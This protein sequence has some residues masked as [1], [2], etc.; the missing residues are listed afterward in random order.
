LKVR[1]IL[2][3]HTNRQ[4]DIARLSKSRSK[5]DVDVQEGKRVPTALH[6]QEKWC[7]GPDAMNETMVP[8]PPTK[9]RD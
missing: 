1:R 3:K 7:M 4:V 5:N 9:K 8:H 2:A 6:T